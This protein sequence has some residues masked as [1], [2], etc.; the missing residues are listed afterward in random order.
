MKKKD[1]IFSVCQLRSVKVFVYF[2]RL[3]M[4]H[5]EAADFFAHTTAKK[6]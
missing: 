2:T 6:N 1:A 5:R 3:K 4:S